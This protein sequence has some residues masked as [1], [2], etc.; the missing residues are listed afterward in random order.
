MG[1]VRFDNFRASA[2]AAT[3]LERTDNMWSW[4]VG[5]ILHPL[6]NTSLYVMHGTSFNPSAEFLTLA[7]ANLN[8][9]PEKNEVTEA[10]AKVDLLGGQLSLTGAVFR[11]DKTNARVPDPTNTAVNILDGLTRIEGFEIGAIGRLTER[12]QVF[13]GYTH[14]RSEI[15]ETTTLSQLGKELL[16]TPNNAF[17]LWTTY[18]VTPYLTVGGGAYYVD[19]MWANATNDAMVPSFWRFDAMA[20]YKITPQAT[21]QLNLYNLTNEYYF[22][23]V[24][25]NW[26]VPAP[27]RYAALTLRMRW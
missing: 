13:A 16:N 9:G 14:L 27:G 4:R 19:E 15:V 2:G 20:A 18:D 25:N 10:G 6:P 23:Q 17:S 22:A 8:L 7:A 3:I 11:I 5:A 12:W 1:G 26:A 21:L 24:Y